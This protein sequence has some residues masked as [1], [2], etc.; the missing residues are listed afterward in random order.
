M[1][2]STLVLPVLVGRLGAGPMRM[3]LQGTSGDESQ[4]LVD[5]EHCLALAWV[6]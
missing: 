4:G 5:P 6:I 2:L 3:E 1:R